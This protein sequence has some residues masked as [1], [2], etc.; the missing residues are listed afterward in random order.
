M[1]W[2]ISSGVSLG[3]ANLARPNGPVLFGMLAIWAIGIIL[4]RELPWQTVVKGAL[5]TL[6][7]AA[8]IIGPW[9]YRNY[10]VSGTFVMVS[11][12]GGDVLLGAYN[13]KVLQHT[14]GLWT[15]SGKKLP[16]ALLA[17]HDSRGYTAEDDKLA[18]GYALQWIQSHL[19]DMPLLIS[20]HWQTMWTPFTSEYAMPYM[21]FRGRF[22]SQVVL[23]MLIYMSTPIFY[24]AALGFLLT[25]RARKRQLL[26]VYASIALTILQNLAFY[27]NMRFRAPIE[28][29][30]VL[31][32][33]GVLWW[34]TGDE[35]GTLSSWREKRKGAQIEREKT[36][37]AI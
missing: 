12:G 32:A 13:D 22:L 2:V 16:R 17:G 8:V 7:L 18:A 5:G 25:W 37:T 36:L 30:L 19:N 20:Y 33:G 3:L 9:T 14:T 35:P 23:Q 29:L 15:F 34:F 4:A 24:L 21:V 11:L 6:L 10:Q 1:R 26:I 31:Q 28:P 27:G